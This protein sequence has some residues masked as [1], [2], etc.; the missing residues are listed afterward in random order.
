LARESFLDEEEE[1]RSLPLAERFT[2][3]VERAKCKS[4]LL[5]FRAEELETGANS[6]RSA[7]GVHSDP[8]GLTLCGGGMS[9]FTARL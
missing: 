4:A 6:P 3:D 1:C 7:Q 8:Q 2:G 9:R 5:H